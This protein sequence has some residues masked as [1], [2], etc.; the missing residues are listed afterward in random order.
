MER[1]KER[2]VFNDIVQCKSIRVYYWSSFVMDERSPYARPLQRANAVRSGQPIKGGRL[3]LEEIEEALDDAANSHGEI[4]A[5]DRIKDQN[6]N[7]KQLFLRYSST[8]HCGGLLEN[9]NVYI[10]Y[11]MI[12]IEF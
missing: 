1:E 2:E 12:L 8:Y 4:A 11:S 3:S 6:L 10:V 5:K 7:V 9:F